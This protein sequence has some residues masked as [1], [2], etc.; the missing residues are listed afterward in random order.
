MPI[1]NIQYIRTT[2]IK[3][4]RI[5]STT[6]RNDDD[7]S[8]KSQGSFNR[9]LQYTLPRNNLSAQAKRKKTQKYFKGENY[10][11]FQIVMIANDDQNKTNEAIHQNKWEW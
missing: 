8:V 1:P 3:K 2:C 4:I 9:N 5:S 7:N 6:L 10:N 11:E